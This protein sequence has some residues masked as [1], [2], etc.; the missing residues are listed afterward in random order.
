MN[1]R[2]TI[3]HR[4]LFVLIVLLTGGAFLTTGCGGDSKKESGKTAEAPEGEKKP[5]KPKK[6]P[7]KPG[8]PVSVV[9]VE[10]GE[11]V[12]TVTFSAT[13]ESEREVVVYPRTSGL[14]RTM[15]V[16]EGARVAVGQVLMILDDAD[17]RIAERQAYIE[18][19]KA[20]KDSVR[21]AELFNQK[22]ISRE[23]FEQAAYQAGS[24]RLNWQKTKLDLSRTRIRAPVR[25]VI[26]SRDV[27]IGDRVGTSSETFKLVTMDNL[28]ARVYVPGRSLPHLNVGQ[29]AHI[30]SDMLPDFDG[31]GAIK[32]ISPVIDPRSGTVKVT[33]GL[34]DRSRKL[35]PGMFVNVALVTD[36][37]NEA[38]LLPK[39]T[40]VYDGRQAYAFVVKD[41]TAS[42]QLLT[43][44][45]KNSRQVQVIEGLAVGDSVVIVG[46]EG[47]R[48]GAKVRVIAD[49]SKPIPREE[50]KK[51]AEDS[52]DT[53]QPGASAS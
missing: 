53:E 3:L 9:A 25:G 42:R 13:V 48:D 40:L 19:E 46:Q 39:E 4:L 24:A 35:T 2:S 47:L 31:R 14:V 15:L 44:G 17:N 32:R 33:V 52:T 20:Q 21:S 22:M 11:I 5:D 16:E 30:S 41:S 51:V 8:V 43:L 6:K 37:R 36:Q 26:S 10:S 18:L 12:S 1:N 45:L 34:I 27:E 23:Q 7:P 28:V 29:R 38:L 49:A 50:T